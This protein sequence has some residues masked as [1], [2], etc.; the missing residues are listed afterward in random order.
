MVLFLQDCLKAYSDEELLSGDDERR[1]E[2][3][4][5]KQPTLKSLRICRG[6]PVL[7]L[8][9]KRFSVSTATFFMSLFDKVSHL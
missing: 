5:C 1:C 7:V 9:L 4:K 3:C 2:R 6:P 8:H